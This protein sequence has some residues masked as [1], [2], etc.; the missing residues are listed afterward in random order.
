MLVLL[1]VA[2]TGAWAETTIVTWTS[3]GSYENNNSR[4]GVTLSGDVVEYIW[5]ELTGGEW[6]LAYDSNQG[7]FMTSLG[8]FTSIVISGGY[9]HGFSGT[10][11]NGKTWTGNASSVP[12]RGYLTDANGEEPWTITFTIAPATVAVTGVTLLPTTATLTLGETETVTLTATVLPDEATDKSVTWSSSNT[13]VATVSNEG[14]VTA[15]AA[16]EATITVT[17][18]DGAKTATCA[19][20]VAAPAAP[21]TKN[22]TIIFNDLGLDNAYDLTT[23]SLNVGNI[24]LNFDKADGSNPPAFYTSGGGTARLYKGN[25]MSVDAGGATITKIVFTYASDVTPTFSTGSYNATTKT[26]EG[27]ATT[28]TVT[29]AYTTNTQIRIMSMDVYYSVAS[30]AGEAAYTVTLKGGTEDADKWTIAPAE[31]TTTGVAQ[32]TEITLTYSGT[33][34]VKSVKAVKEPEPKPAA[35]ATAEDKGK[36]IGVDGKIYADV[37]AATAAGTTAVAKIIYIGTTGHATYS[38]GLALAL[39]DEASKMAWEA[40][41]DACS[42]KNTSTPVTGA[43]WLLASKDQ[44]DYMMG[45]NGAGSYA[46]LRSASNLQWNYYWSSTESDSD[47]SRAWYYYFA[48]GAWLNVLKGSNNW[49]RACLAF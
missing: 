1:M 39:T 43:T 26:W 42:A 10:G 19:V 41:I 47:S 25:T 46:D 6:R 16:G 34:R 4:G 11:W 17:T 14:V 2:V 8:N 32:G 3:S 5:D 28:L 15:V 20:T 40:A 49:V 45:A 9:I 30:A 36:V 13:S 24:K 23:A 29:N 27:E 7:T 33:K 37:A 44:W 12:F 22:V 48:S 31:A 18:T 35:E 21:A 38:H